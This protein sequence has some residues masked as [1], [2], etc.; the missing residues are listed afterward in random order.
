MTCLVA[1]HSFE[2]CLLIVRIHWKVKDFGRDLQRL[3]GNPGIQLSLGS[4]ALN[5]WTVSLEIMPANLHR[6]GGQG[7]TN[8]VLG[9]FI[10][11]TSSNSTTFSIKKKLK[12]VWLEQN[13][14]NHLPKILR[15]QPN[16]NLKLQ[17]L[18]APQTC[19]CHLRAHLVQRMWCMLDTQQ[20]LSF[21][22][23]PTLCMRQNPYPRAESCG[24]P[25]ASWDSC[26]FM[27]LLF[28][29]ISRCPHHCFGF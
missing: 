3:H 12:I 16:C 26:G 20:V 17:H 24:S 14:F 5:W 29:I 11:F 25:T 27:A 22:K 9:F 18:W 28:P 15:L 23:V 19:Y 13:E 10:S 7:K 8:M 4:W 6:K 2:I 1:P 21:S